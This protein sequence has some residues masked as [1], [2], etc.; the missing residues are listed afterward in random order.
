M[1]EF[2]N[3]FTKESTRPKS[4]MKDFVLLLSP[5]AP[6]LC[7]ELW[8]ILGHSKTLAYEPWPQFDP[9][10]TL[11]ASIEVPVQIN[12]KVKAKIL[13]DADISK[14]DLELTAKSDE[15]IARMIG[16]KTIVKAIVIPGRMVNFVVK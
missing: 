5:F 13:V 14:E 4:A 16:D 11:D 9:A 8:S 2:V 10:L 3:F 6:H 15:K 12:G 7:E 1:M